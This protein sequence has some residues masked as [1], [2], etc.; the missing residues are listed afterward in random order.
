MC[1]W[2]LGFGM[3]VEENEGSGGMSM[4]QGYE[5]DNSLGF[6]G[7]TFKGGIEIETPLVKVKHFFTGEILVMVG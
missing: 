3:D 5:N 7:A 4:K 6:T 2:Y 1:G